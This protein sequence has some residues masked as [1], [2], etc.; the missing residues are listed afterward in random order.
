MSVES[1]K[2]DSSGTELAI[3]GE[4]AEAV[5]SAVTLVSANGISVILLLAT[6]L[7][8]AKEIVEN[9]IDAKIVIKNSLLNNTG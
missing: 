5:T 7:S 3:W 1:V 6:M 9:E 8:S 2:V 4:E